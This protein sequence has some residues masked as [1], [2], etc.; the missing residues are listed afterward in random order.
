M[1]SALGSGAFV[2][3][4]GKQSVIQGKET[5]KPALLSWEDLSFQETTI[6]SKKDEIFPIVLVHIEFSREKHHIFS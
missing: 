5:R 1:N 2:P 3:W 4:V 6:E